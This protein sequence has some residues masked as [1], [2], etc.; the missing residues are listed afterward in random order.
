MTESDVSNPEDVT[1]PLR[2]RIPEYLTIFVL[3]WLGVA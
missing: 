2:D 1:L 3:G